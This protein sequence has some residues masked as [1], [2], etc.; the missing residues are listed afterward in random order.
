MALPTLVILDRI[1]QFMGLD[2][3]DLVNFTER[4]VRNELI[5][6]VGRTTS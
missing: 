4:G 3:V 1:A 6:S 5:V 2:L